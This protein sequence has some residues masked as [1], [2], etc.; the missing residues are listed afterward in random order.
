[1]HNHGRNTAIPSPTEQHGRTAGEEVRAEAKARLSSPG[2]EAVVA[3]GSR[4]NAESER[5]ILDRVSRSVGPEEYRR[6][7]E[8]Q[9]RVRIDGKRV[10]ITVPTGFMADMLGRRF[11]ESLRRAAGEE[12]GATPPDIELVFRVDR[13]AFGDT[14][15]IPGRSERAE[16]RAIPKRPAPAIDKPSR[17]KLDDFEVGESN[18]LAHAAAAR[19]TDPDCPRSASPLF[20]HGPCGVGKTH[21]LQGIVMRMKERGASVVYL[22][23]ESFMNEY[24]IALRTNKMDGFRKRYRGVDLLCIDDVQFLNGKAGTQKE[25]LHTFDAIDL[26]GA[27]VVLAS[28]EHPRR[29]QK[30]SEALVSR[31]VA[32]MVVRIDPPDV[33]LRGRIVARLAERRGLSLDAAGA[34]MIASSFAGAAP[35]ARD[36]EGVL[37]RIEAMRSLPGQAAHNAVGLVLIRKA[38]GVSESEQAG[39]GGDGRR[40]VRPVRFT[41]IIDEVCRVLRVDAS[42]LFGK[43]RHKRVVLARSMCAALGRSL[44]T[45]SYPE[46]ARGLGR[47]NHSTVITAVKRLERQMGNEATASV[48]LYL[49]SDLDGAAGELAGLSLRMLADRLRHDITRSAP[50]A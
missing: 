19:M 18:R 42:E 46:I 28:D 50:G 10:Q 43:G 24:V 49:G 37:T 12:L 44:T 27:R 2:A 14:G 48:G 23:A 15:R 26:S 8:H 6:Y 5:G 3:P 11:G 45:M 31:F 25:L 47:P 7:F 33:A 22:T 41:H 9:T 30:L 39:G 21:L 13:G 38:L 29:V 34:A 35:T 17:Y 32:G 36:I 40:P 16:P 1:M 4:Q 20:I